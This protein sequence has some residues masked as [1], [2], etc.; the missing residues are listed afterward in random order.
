MRR[1]L[2]IVV[3]LALLMAVVAAPAAAAGTVDH[4][5]DRGETLASIAYHYGT[6][7]SA[8][9]AA[10]PSIWNP[11]IIWAGMHL[12]VPVGDYQP[13]QPPGSTGSPCSYYVVRYG[14]TMISIARWFGV[15]VWDLARQNVIYNL[16]RIYA[17]MYLQIPCGGYATAV[18][19]NN[20]QGQYGQYGYGDPN[21]YNSQG[22]YDTQ[23]SMGALDALV[24]PAQAVPDQSMTD[25][26]V[27]A[28]TIQYTVQ[29][30]DNL[31]IIAARYGT[32]VEAILD[33]NQG[34][35]PY[36]NY[37]MRGQVITVPVGS[38]AV[39]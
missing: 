37:L 39:G 7:I 3:L 36:G 32:T 11:N 21:M 28:Q 6:T 25:Q 26:A 29:P 9:L 16:N 17:G 38:D 1:L 20:Y 23:S 22:M 24:A 12:Q 33:L 10:N 15:D 27:P 31:T 14:D 8:I 13:P 34:V 4:I 18:P 5:V 30:G 2:L 35:I 19:Y